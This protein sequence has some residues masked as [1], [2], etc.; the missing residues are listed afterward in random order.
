MKSSLLALFG[1]VLL[2]ACGPQTATTT[3]S[4][5]EADAIGDAL[6][7][8]RPAAVIAQ[9]NQLAIDTSGIDHKPSSAGEQLGPHRSSRAMAIVH[10]AMFD[11]VNSISGHYF[12]YSSLPPAPSTAT[13]S[14]AAAQAAHDALASLYPSQKAA[15]D[16]LL[17]THLAAFVDGRG[18]NNGILVGQRAAQ[19][20]LAARVNDG[21]AYREPIV[22]VD[23]PLATGLGQWTPDPLNHNLTALGAYWGKVKPFVIS[24]GKRYRAPPPPSLLS[25][26]Y[27][28]A[29]NDAMA[30]GGDG[31]TT[32]TSRTTL[33]SNIG[34]FWAYD[35]MPSLCAPPR[36]YNQIAMQIARDQG[37]A[38]DANELIYYL[39]LVN[40]AMADAAIS[41]WDSKYYYNFWRPVTAA[42]VDDGNANT[43]TI[44]NFTPIGAPA[45]NTSNPN[46]T[47]PFPTYPSGHATFGGA[48]FEVIRNYYGTDAIAFDF[49]SDEFNGKTAGHDGVV[50]PVWKRH[51]S[52]LSQAEEENGQSR[53]YLGIH[54]AFDKT[55]GITMGNRVGDAVFYSFGY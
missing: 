27:A 16:T 1:A 31:V 4:S 12:T 6:T 42:R 3:D 36:L 10:I 46:F 8:L 49:T 54:W 13:M 55:S 17:A 41:A 29:Y 15:F 19:A 34:L 44:W 9:W 18:K 24:S 48:L 37:T 28:N 23:I 22:G 32:P 53:I 35:G 5:L 21:S 30:L 52:S 11:A 43:A 14:V 50:R 40:V 20:I 39:A 2:S 38:S 25:N 45:S 7:A 26:T 33:Q 47:P 51:F